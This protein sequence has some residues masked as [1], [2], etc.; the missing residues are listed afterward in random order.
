[1]FTRPFQSSG[2]ERPAVRAVSPTERT[3]IRTYTFWSDLGMLV[4]TF[5]V[6]LRGEPD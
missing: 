1:M 6:V 5:L 3:D 4:P 2:A